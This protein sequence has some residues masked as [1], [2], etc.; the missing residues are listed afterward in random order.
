MRGKN[1]AVIS[2]RA[3]R[4]NDIL[5][6]QRCPVIGCCLSILYSYILCIGF[7]FPNQEIEAFLMC[8]CSN[9]TRAESYLVSNKLIGGIS[10]ERGNAENNLFFASS[11]GAFSPPGPH[12]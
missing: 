6:F 7:K 12:P 8:G 3:E 10:I 4:S 11:F 1:D 5:K 9:N 2:L